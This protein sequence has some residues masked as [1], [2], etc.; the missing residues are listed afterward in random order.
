MSDERPLSWQAL[1]SGLTGL[2]GG[3]DS[4]AGRIYREWEGWFTRQAAAARSADP[5]GRLAA[6]IEA[7]QLAR[8]L[9]DGAVQ[10]AVSRAG[11]GE[12]NP[13]DARIEALTARVDALTARIETLQAE[14]DR[15]R[16]QD[17]GMTGEG[18][19]V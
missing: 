16:R 1:F 18:Q 11:I 17:V 5:S 13:D 19:G 8:R 12:A 3:A 10:A 4:P 7:A 6:A 9:L 15:L 2:D 14:V